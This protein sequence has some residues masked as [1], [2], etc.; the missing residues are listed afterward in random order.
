[1]RS[2]S[3]NGRSP[4]PWAGFRLRAWA[5]TLATLLGL[6]GI[7]SL[8]Q[9]DPGAS[10]SG[11]ITGMVRDSWENAPL[12]GVVVVVRGTTLAVKSEPDGRFQIENVP[13]GEHTVVFSR[14]GFA[15]ATVTQVRVG[16]GQTS[17]VDLALRP[18]FYEMEEYEVT[19]EELADQTESLLFE[20]QTALSMTDAIGSDMF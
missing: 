7:I 20:R 1:M 19:A 8:G 18:E 2:T 12:S 13:A 6:S 3:S 10:G 14:S 5:W 17:T 9:T 15:R 16:A 11:R 4:G